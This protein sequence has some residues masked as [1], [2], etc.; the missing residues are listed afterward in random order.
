MPSLIESGYVYIAQPPLYRVARK[1]VFQYIRSEKE[2]DDYLF[3][4]GMSDIEL[5]RA[6]HHT[7]ISK[8][9]LKKVVQIIV[10]LEQFIG[11]IERKGMP[12]KEFIHSRNAE[13]VYPKFLVNVGQ[14]QRIAYIREEL[15]EFK[16]LDL[17]MQK[18]QFEDTMASIPE[19]ERAKM[20]QTFFAKPLHYV[21]IYDDRRLDQIQEVL[22]Q[23]ELSL[24][25]Y[26]IAEG[27]IFDVIDESTKETPLYTLREL[28][29]FLR[30]N[31]R[32]GVE[33]QRYKG[34]G[35]MNADQLWETTMDPKV[36]TLVKVTMEDAISADHMFSML[37][38]EE[39]APRRAF[40]ETHALS[41]KNLDV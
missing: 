14:T 15:E 5:R 12:F 41:V 39:V 6:S 20:T 23:Y 40:I 37:M 26:S 21:E 19:D 3:H 10:E 16:E 4:L 29:D 27:K 34:L 2:L 18:Q 30:E 22:S 33:L 36:R 9:E 31:G 32:K 24:K 17:Q 13:G 8:E 35:E 25:Q 28:I 7:V 11:S 1:K 38:G